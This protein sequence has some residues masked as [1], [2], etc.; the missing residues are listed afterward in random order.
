MKIVSWNCR[1][2]FDDIKASAICKYFP[3]TDIF[4]IQECRRNDIYALKDGYK[5]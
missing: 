1:N 3:K 4:V 5:F 2:G